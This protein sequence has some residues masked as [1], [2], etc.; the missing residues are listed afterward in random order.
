MFLKQL[1]EKMPDNSTVQ[2]SITKRKGKISVV[3]TEQSELNVDPNNIDSELI[4]II[5]GN[6]IA[7]PNIVNISP[8]NRAPIVPGPD[9]KQPEEKIS[10]PKKA[11]EPSEKEKKIELQKKAREFIAK[12]SELFTAKDYEGALELFTNAYELDPKNKYVEADIEKCKKWIKAI[13]DMEASTSP[14][15][16]EEP[17]SKAPEIPLMATNDLLDQ[18]MDFEIQVMDE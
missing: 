4:K 15:P 8:E 7:R 12:G 13:A 3:I 11:K 17:V 6:D 18:G 1:T 9:S 2:M 16:K 5:G 10:A 14:K